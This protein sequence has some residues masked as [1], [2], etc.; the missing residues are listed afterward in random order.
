MTQEEEIKHLT[1]ELK[2]K[3]EDL[4][5]NYEQKALN[6]SKLAIMLHY[7][8]VKDTADFQYLHGLENAIEIIDGIK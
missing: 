5:C 7:N 4:K 3:L 2:E 8:Q 1:E 6:N